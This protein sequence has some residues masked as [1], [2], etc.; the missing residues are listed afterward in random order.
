MSFESRSKFVTSTGSVTR[1]GEMS[2]LWLNFKS[3]GNFASVLLSKNWGYF[4]LGKNLYLVWQF[5]AIE[6][7]SLFQMTK[8]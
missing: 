4:V 8:Y 1:F 5:F 6:Q 7:F 3:V 2:P